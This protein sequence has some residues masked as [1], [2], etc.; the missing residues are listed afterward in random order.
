MKRIGYKKLL[1]SAMI[2]ALLIEFFVPGVNY[3]LAQSETN[4]VAAECGPADL[5]NTTQVNM[6]ELYQSSRNLLSLA[7]NGKPKLKIDAYDYSELKKYSVLYEAIK[8]DPEFLKAYQQ[9]P[10]ISDE[11]KKEFGITS[12]PS[13]F[14]VR[15]LNSIINLVTPKSA[16]GAGREWIKVASIVKGYSSEKTGNPLKIADSEQIKKDGANFINSLTAA[17]YKQMGQAA[18]ITEIDKL[19]GTKFVYKLDENG[20]EVLA[21]KIKMDDMPIQVAWQ[22]DKATSSVQDTPS[23]FGTNM[24]TVANN[25]FSQELNSTLGTWLSEQGLDLTKLGTGYITDLGGNLAN[26]TNNVSE[27]WLKDNWDIP[28]NTILGGNLGYTGNEIGQNTFSE[29]LNSLIPSSGLTGTSTKEMLINAGREKLASNMGLPEYSFQDGGMDSKKLLDSIGRRVMENNLGLS[30]GSLTGSSANKDDLYKKIGQGFIENA[31]NLPSGSFAGNSQDEIKNAVGISKFQD[32]ID[33]SDYVDGILYLD[34]GTTANGINSPD[35]FKLTVGKKVIENEVDVYAK[36]SDG[37]DKRDQ[38]FNLYNP[39]KSGIM[40]KFLDNDQNIFS[41]IGINAVSKSLSQDSNDQKV[42]RNWLETGQI[43]TDPARNNTPKVNEELLSQSV[44]LK[45]YDLWRLFVYNQGND[46]FE[47]YGW[48]TWLSAIAPNYDQNESSDINSSPELTFY[49]TRYTQIKDQISNLGKST[50][51]TTVKALCEEIYTLAKD[52]ETYGESTQQISQTLLWPYEEK[53]KNYI[54]KIAGKISEI[55]KSEPNIDLGSTKKLAYEIIDGNSLTDL[56]QVSENDITSLTRPYYLNPDYK[57]SLMQ[58]LRNQKSLNDF[59][60]EQGLYYLGSVASLDNPSNLIG[61]WRTIKNNT[62]QNST[63]IL[64]NALGTDQLN[65]IAEEIN[66]GFGLAPL[67]GDSDYYKITAEDVAKLLTGSNLTFNIKLGSYAMDKALYLSPGNGS[68][69]IIKGASLDSVMPTSGLNR[70]TSQIL[71]LIENSPQDGNISDNISKLYLSE[72]LGLNKNFAFNTAN[73]FQEPR[74]YA[75]VLQAFGVKIPDELG[76]DWTKIIDWAKSTQPWNESIYQNSITTQVG[77]L[78]LNLNQ[79]QNFLSSVFSNSSTNISIDSLI[80]PIK[81]LIS[82]NYFEKD[83]LNEG[84]GLD[85]AA[86]KGLDFLLYTATQASD[87]KKAFENSDSS[88]FFNLL[89]GGATNTIM[90]GSNFAWDSGALGDPKNANDLKS[91]SLILPTLSN[92]KNKKAV[93]E[94]FITFGINAV[95]SYFPDAMKYAD[96]ASY[97]YNFIQAFVGGITNA[98]RNQRTEDAAKKVAEGTTKSLL[99]SM[100][101]VDEV[102]NDINKALGNGTISFYDMAVGGLTSLND[103]SLALKE[104]GLDSNKINSEYNADIPT[105]SLVKEQAGVISEEELKTAYEERMAQNAKVIEAAVKGTQQDVSNL[106]KQK[107]DT[108]SRTSQDGL[109]KGYIEDYF[110]STIDAQLMQNR[111]PPLARVLIKGTPDQKRE[112]MRQFVVYSLASGQGM[113][114]WGAAVADILT[115]ALI[116]KQK[117]DPKE[118]S[119]AFDVALAGLLKLDFVPAGLGQGF[120]S[121]ILE[122]DTTQVMKG[123]QDSAILYGTTFLDKTLGL[124][125]GTTYTMYSMWNTY[126]TALTAYNTAVSN[127]ATAMDTYSFYSGIGASAEKLAELQSKV[128]AA[129]AAKS[130]AMDK[131]QLTTASIASTAVNMIFGGTFQKLDQNLGLP[132]GTVSLI[133][134]TAIYT[135]LGGMTLQAALGL[136]WPAAALT[137]LPSLFGIFGG[138]KPNSSDQVT[139]IEV[140]YSACG[141]Y[142]GIDSG[143]PSGTES[144]CPAEFH[145]ETQEL[146]M[147]GAMAAA[148]FVIQDRLLPNLLTMGSRMGDSAMEP[149]RIETLQQTHVNQ[150]MPLADKAYCGG[151]SGCMVKEINAGSRRG[152]GPNQVLWD[153][154]YYAY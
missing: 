10:V 84:F 19:R 3:A 61:I 1:I 56:S 152:F 37:S 154:V 73:Y 88:N 24:S 101:N 58:V 30:T 46:V 109:R 148:N 72:N 97:A 149:N 116:D 110:L 36:G 86:S 89:A 26:I 48:T 50:N 39:D 103:Y 63:N 6:D 77:F 90:N 65:S 111:M 136:L 7:D 44:N 91:L 75:R 62:N 33:N 14:D 28:F 51:N 128:T 23:E 138:K 64:A 92:G 114:A 18:D 47:R 13:Q 43:E 151:E 104:A 5:V 81:Q 133:V 59:I 98:E 134:T 69:E 11:L 113:P 68:K 129:D 117:V 112:A 150:N 49:R 53:T 60:E 132:S 120:S 126:Q 140:I 122:G 94:G 31:L 139:R 108:I 137:L 135:F 83:K 95:T 27:L 153:R 100:A 102:N 70:F 9:N 35:N 143:P 45:A 54:A 78:G 8:N 142:P 79:A 146:F 144:N 85:G 124:P 12:D 16:G 17:H 141:Y 71:G 147:K 131:L 4:S 115:K 99:A 21:E 119:A 145:G 22:T 82:Q 67:G 38:V 125:Q 105:Y 66:N 123:L 41:E 15:I 57:T 93:E 55:E 20:N 40:Q 121:W 32:I 106:V 34:I 42:I 118:L 127:I 76:S 87:I 25:F 107:Q 74:N 130:I 52:M 96:K 29:T 80:S 2:F